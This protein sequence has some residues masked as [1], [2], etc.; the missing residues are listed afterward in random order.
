MHQV[1]FQ[2]YFRGLIANLIYFL[3]LLM[4]IWQ[5]DLVKEIYRIKTTQ[6]IVLITTNP[7]YRNSTAIDSFR[8]NKED[9]LVKPSM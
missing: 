9:I 2:L 3:L 4:L 1:F 6:R 7:P 8:V 5:S